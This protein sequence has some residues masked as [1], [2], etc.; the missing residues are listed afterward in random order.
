MSETIVYN[1]MSEDIMKQMLNYTH[2]EDEDLNEYFTR[3]R[4]LCVNKQL[5]AGNY[6][7]FDKYQLIIRRKEY[8]NLKSPYG[9]VYNELKEPICIHI[10]KTLIQTNAD[11]IA[12]LTLQRI[13]NMFPSEFKHAG[14]SIYERVN[15]VLNLDYMK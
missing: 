14:K 7:A 11:N 3:D 6:Y 8:N 9:W 12:R 10:D 1:I 5:K 2:N 4:L 15:N 13:R